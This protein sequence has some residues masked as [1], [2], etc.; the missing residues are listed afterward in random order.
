MTHIYFIRHAESDYSIRKSSIRPLTEKGL[1]D[2]SLVTD[3]LHNK[4]ID[5]VLS[6]PYKRTVDTLQ[7][8]TNKYNFEMQTIEDFREMRSDSNYRARAIDF[9][10]YMKHLWADFNYRLGDGET[11]AECQNRNIV[12]LEKVLNEYNG[13]NIAIGTHGIALSAIV[14]HYDDT[15]GYEDFM[16][17]AF[18]F[19]WVVKMSFDQ[20]NCVKIEKIDIRKGK[21]ND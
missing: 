14:N 3:F 11:L 20:I 4:N 5:I 12:A 8:F 7:D 1:A 16:A 10:T 15:F 21:N 19:P 17:M 13:K 2:C 9:A 18:V 6:S